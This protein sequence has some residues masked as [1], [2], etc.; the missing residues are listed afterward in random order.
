MNK[1]R[2]YAELINRTSFSAIRGALSCRMDVA[3]ARP[4]GTSFLGDMIVTWRVARIQAPDANALLDRLATLVSTALLRRTAT[5]VVAG[6]MARLVAW[7]GN[8][9]AAGDAPRILELRDAR[10]QYADS[11]VARG[12]LFGKYQDDQVLANS[13]SIAVA[14]PAQLFPPNGRRNYTGAAADPKASAP[15]GAL[16]SALAY[17]TDAATASAALQTLWQQWGRPIAAFFGLG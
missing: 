2:S 15:R 9:V 6:E 4:L 17:I 5:A 11:A 10:R 13:R 12:S 3:P 16:R 7:V 8:T 1:L 14:I